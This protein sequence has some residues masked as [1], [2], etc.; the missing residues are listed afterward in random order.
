MLKQKCPFFGK[1]GGCVWQDLSEADYLAK[2]ESFIRRAFADVG[3]NEIPLNPIILLPT[4]IRR[5]ACFA[6]YQGHFGFNEAHSH[7]IIEIDSCPLLEPALNALIPDLR[8]LVKTLGGSGDCFI[9]NTPTGV[10][11]HIK[12]GRGTPDLS[13]LEILSALAQKENVVRLTYNNSPIFQKAPLPILPEGFLQPSVFGEKTLVDLVLKNVRQAKNAV[14]LFCGQGTF[15]R[16]LMK[17][18]LS[19]TGYDNDVSVLT[20]GDNG[21]QRDLFRNPVTPDELLGVD[22]AVL[23]PPRAG[24]KEQVIQLASTQIPR[25]IMVSCAPKTGAR[26]IKIL[27]DAGWYL[28][29]ITPVDQFTYSNHIEIVAILE[30]K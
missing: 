15:T 3:L 20:L 6:F 8:A 25:I 22:L 28:T 18:G 30:K 24:A 27:T 2:K 11:I 14:D 29:E 9:L 7:K 19:V 5:R 13:R 17:A 4:G 23:D 12:D 21:R 10:D 1:C 26:D 16:P